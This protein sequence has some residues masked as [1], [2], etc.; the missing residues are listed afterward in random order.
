M[1]AL[2]IPP[3]FIKAFKM[4]LNTVIRQRMDEMVSSEGIEGNWEMDDDSYIVSG[5]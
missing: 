4:Q 1:I 3:V 2:Y 5:L